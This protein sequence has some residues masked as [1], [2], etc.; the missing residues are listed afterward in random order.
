MVTAYLLDAISGTI[1]AVE[2]DA[3]PNT[4]GFDKTVKELLFDADEPSAEIFHGGKMKI[5]I[6]SSQVPVPTNN[7]VLFSR[8]E[9]FLTPDQSASNRSE[10]KFYHGDALIVGV[11]KKGDV[12]SK[13]PVSIR[14][15]GKVVRLYSDRYR[16]D[17]FET[18]FRI[19]RAA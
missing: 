3:V 14:D 5:Y 16:T 18:R 11:N 4:K 1:S 8:K 19:R 15:M 9:K 6:P 2:I 13:P 12:A 10:Y 17:S 7:G